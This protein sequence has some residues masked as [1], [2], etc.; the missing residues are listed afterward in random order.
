ML[1]KNSISGLAAFF[2]CAIILISS[3]K[4]NDDV[5]SPS[6]AGGG[7]NQTPAIVTNTNTTNSFTIT[8]NDGQ[9]IGINGTKPYVNPKTGSGMSIESCGAASGLFVVASSSG[10]CY[11]TT[12]WIPGSGYCV[13]LYINGQPYKDP[14]TGYG[15]F[16]NTVS[17]VNAAISGG[18]SGGQAFNVFVRTYCT[19]DTT[20][21]YYDC[22]VNAYVAPAGFSCSGGGGTTGGGTTGGGTTTGHHKH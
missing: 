18:I 14:N 20:G 1:I 21:S 19:S 16:I 13:A 5:S 8:G 22:P 15:L 2:A 6:S 7:N 9:T 3:C 10:G 4:K 17:G 12:A 11:L